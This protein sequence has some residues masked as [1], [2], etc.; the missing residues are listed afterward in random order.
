MTATRQLEQSPQLNGIKI[1]LA[2]KLVP[3]RPTKGCAKMRRS[4]TLSAIHVAIGDGF[5]EPLHRT[6]LF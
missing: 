6:L 4:V 1:S 5:V 3:W 2:G